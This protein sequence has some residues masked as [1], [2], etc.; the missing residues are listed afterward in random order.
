M[1]TAAGIQP[2]RRDRCVHRSVRLRD[3]LGLGSVTGSP[4][5]CRPGATT[6]PH[7]SKEIADEQA[8]TES[9]HPERALPC[10]VNEGQHGFRVLVPFRQVRLFSAK[11]SVA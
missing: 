7:L 2:L 10:L 5:D 1:G 4:Q 8:R 11:R 3:V 6:W 9:G